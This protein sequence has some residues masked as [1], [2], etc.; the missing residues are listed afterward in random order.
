MN[1]TALL[2]LANLFKHLCR[3]YLCHLVH[4]QL[5]LEAAAFAKFLM[6]V[7]KCATVVCYPFEFE[8]GTRFMNRECFFFLGNM[9][10][11]SPGNTNGENA[12]YLE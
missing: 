4:I 8:F 6:L 3:S 2:A 5:L 7:R 1:R 10:N 11:E 9:E 12:A